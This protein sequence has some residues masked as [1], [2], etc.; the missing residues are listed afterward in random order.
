MSAASGSDDISALFRTQAPGRAFAAFAD[1]LASVP[2][3]DRS[4][5]RT[6][7]LD[8]LHEVC[9]SA[10]VSRHEWLE[11][12]FSAAPA[13]LRV[14][15][16]GRPDFMAHQTRLCGL[17]IEILSDTP[18]G[19]RADL[20]TRLIPGLADLSLPCALFRVANGG[21]GADHAETEQES[22]YFGAGADALR[23]KLLDLVIRRAD[24]GRLW[25]EASPGAL[26]WFWFM[27]GEEQRVYVFTKQAMRD[28]S[29]LAALLA[30][31]VERVSS[32]QGDHDVVPVRR[33]SKIIDLHALEAQALGLAVSA[34][35]RA[36]RARARR[37]LDAFAT[38]KSELFR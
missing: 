20:I 22:V 21:P 16:D 25:Q 2:D 31:P 29:A 38:G 30:V 17:V 34:P 3:P 4:P 19:E 35:L 18:P 6:A 12:I 7:C 13:F 27:F 15:Q 26:L 32:M 8:A 5:L 24:D 33:W 36:D 1:R 11:A 10:K 28:P 23:D 37:F 14:G 9:E